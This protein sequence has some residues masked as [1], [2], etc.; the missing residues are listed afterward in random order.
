M[1]VTACV[2]LSKIVVSIKIIIQIIKNRLRNKQ[3][4]LDQKWDIQA[5]TIVHEIGYYQ[6]MKKKL[7]HIHVNNCLKRMLISNTNVELELKIKHLI[8]DL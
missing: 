7:V 5:Q 3:L 1:I 6:F 8:F 4:V 2:K